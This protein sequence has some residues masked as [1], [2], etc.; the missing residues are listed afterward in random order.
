MRKS[1]LGVLRMVVIC[2]SFVILTAC[3]MVPAGRHD[4]GVVI[5]PRLP[6]IVIL[7]DEPYYYHSGYYY[8]YQNDR[9]FYSNAKKGPWKDLPRGHYPKE[10]K[11]KGR[12]DHKDKDKDWKDGHDNGR[13]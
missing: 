6:E 7:V 11:Y 5:V 9:W 1:I 4:S 10:V 8:H 2:A 3:V 13:D 12:G